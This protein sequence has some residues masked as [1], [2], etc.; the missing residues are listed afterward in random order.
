MQIKPIGSNKTELHLDSGAI[1][2]FSYQTPVAAFTGNNYVRTATKYSDTTSKHINQWLDGVKAETVP[3][4]TLDG[5]V[6][7]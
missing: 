5:M 7:S 1:I 4:E 3:Q 6:K 2:L